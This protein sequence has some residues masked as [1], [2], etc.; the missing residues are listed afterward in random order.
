MLYGQQN[1]PTEFTISTTRSYDEI[2]DDIEVD[3]IFTGPGGQKWK[4]PA[5]GTGTNVFRV[6]F[7]APRPGEYVWQSVC[8]NPDDIGLHGQEGKLQVVSYN[9]P[10][11][12]F[13]HGRLRVA[14]TKR[15]LE[16]VDGTP[17]FWMG[18]T[19]WFGLVKRFD[20]PDGVKRLVADRNAKGFNL[21]QIVAGPLPDIDAVDNPWDSQ[22]ANEA[23]LSWDQG[24]TRINP[25]FYDMADLRIAYLVE[26]GLVPCIVGMWGYFLPYMGVDKV[27]KHWRNLV[28]RYAAYPV[29][30]CSAGEVEMATYSQKGKDSEHEREKKC[31]AQEEDWTK[32]TRYVR[33]IDPYHNPITVHPGNLD[34]RARLHDDSILDINMLQTSHSGYCSL[35][36]S[37]TALRECITKEPTMPTLIGE[38][39][40][41]GIMGGSWQEVQRFLFWTSITSGACGH[42]YGAQGIWAMNSADDPH[43]G[44]SGNWGNGFWQEVMHYPGSTHVGIGRRFFE[45]YPWWLFSPR[46][47]PEAKKH[48]RISAY[49]TGISGAV[50]I[51]YLPV[52]CMNDELLGLLV[53]NWFNVLDIRIE[54]GAC[55]RAFYFNPRTGEELRSYT[56]RGMVKKEMGNVVPNENSVWTPPPK[57]TLEDWVLVLENREKL[58]KVH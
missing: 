46:E 21:I 26:N 31:I 33:E 50:A 51:F 22:Q 36:S 35:K 18:D 25:G 43:N 5:F 30:W 10:C 49:A 55:Y 29:V 56:A 3:V 42:T 48:G 15:T 53:G 8:T 6:C 37:V 2:I 54:P 40:Y 41:E 32:V 23:G 16:H 12:L 39:C 13:R 44:Y 20:W 57:P 14:A 17:F 19:W 24:W 47:E 58:S 1:V 11:E 28:A 27:K 7:A 45:R 34:G 9:G 52:S 4:V 38:A